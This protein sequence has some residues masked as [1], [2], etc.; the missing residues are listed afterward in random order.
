MFA[1]L[2]LF[3]LIAVEDDE[4]GLRQDAFREPS[5][6][7][8][9]SSEEERMEPVVYSTSIANIYRHRPQNDWT[10]DAKHSA[11]IVG[12]QVQNAAYNPNPPFPLAS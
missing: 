10:L 4:V 6:M 11:L 12:G 9:E 7:S 5:L 1:T 2:I 8:Q 3:F